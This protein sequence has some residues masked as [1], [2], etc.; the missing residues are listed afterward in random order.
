MYCSGSMLSVTQPTS[1][2]RSR[3]KLLNSSPAATSKTTV[4]PISAVRSDFRIAVRETLLAPMR[5]ETCRAFNRVLPVVE[6]AGSMPATS[7]AANISRHANPITA[8][9]RWMLCAV[10]RSLH[11]CARNFVAVPT[12]EC[13]PCRRSRRSARSRSAARESGCRATLPE[14]FVS[15][16]PCAAPLPAQ[17][18]DSRD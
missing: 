12:A 11:A 8:P 15:P 16:R 4:I 13:R 6:S 2:G 5:A 7:A 3:R 9:S 18:A 17:S 14:R 10:G 1:A